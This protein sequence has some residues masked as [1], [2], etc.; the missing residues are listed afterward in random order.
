MIYRYITD[1]HSNLFVD[2]L[3][4]KALVNKEIEK[5]LLTDF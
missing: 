2:E 1:G 3:S 4:L 5:L